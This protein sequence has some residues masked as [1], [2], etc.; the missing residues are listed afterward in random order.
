MFSK[1]T[2]IQTTFN[3]S[4]AGL[5]VGAPVKYRGVTIGHVRAI[6][7]P[8]AVN[9]SAS[10]ETFKYIIVEMSVN[11]DAVGNMDDDHL[12]QA[13]QRMVKD[14]LRARLD[15]SGITGTAFVNLNYVDPAAHPDTAPPFPTDANYVP[16]VPGALNQVVDGVTDI[17]SKLQQARIDQVIGNANRLILHI[18]DSVQ[19]LKVAQMRAKLDPTL[20]HLQTITARVDDLLKNGHLDESAAHLQHTLAQSDELLA[21]QGDNLRAILTDLR[22]TAANARELSEQVKENPSRLIVDQPPQR[23][24]YG[25]SR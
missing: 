24:S 10:P 4:I 2:T 12:K 13:I 23:A 22:A 15:Q 19:S 6:R 14:G 25:G 1:S 5:E 20:D 3:E 17:V 16:S 21:S 9:F 7:F 11:S 8:N 18:D